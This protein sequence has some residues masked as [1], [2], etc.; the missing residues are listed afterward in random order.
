MG[1]NIGIIGIGFIGGSLIKSLSKSKKVNSITAF[2]TNK[3]SLEKALT[4]G[5]ITDYTLN[6]DNKFSNCDII[7]LCTP[8][9]YIVH[10]AKILKS[11]VKKDCIITDIVQR[12]L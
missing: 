6:V 2:D 1:L 3:D 8:V 9:S 11:I 4:D 10:Y 12:K 5:F 7:F